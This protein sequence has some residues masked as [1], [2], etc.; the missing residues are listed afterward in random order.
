M[1]L[2]RITLTTILVMIT[3]S[4][5]SQRKRDL[6]KE[7]RA[8]EKNIV[9]NASFNNEYSEVWDAI[10]IIATEEYNTISRESESRSYIEALQE[11]D[12]FKEYI[13]IEIR[14][15]KPPYRVSFQ[16]K[17][18]KRA[19]KDDGSFTN[20]QTHSSSTLRS[21]Y[22]R[23]QKRL[24]QLLNG[25]IELS[26]KLQLKIEEYNSKQSKERKKILKGKDY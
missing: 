26:E 20:W 19:K 16:V 2:K 11:N 24:Y 25:S 5:F 23:L 9:S 18:E 13:T 14:S 15:T 12:T 7:I 1:N 4:M 21:Y 17:Q 10:Y 3:I 8:Y 6:I 22:L